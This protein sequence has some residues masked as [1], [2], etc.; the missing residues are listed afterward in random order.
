MFLGAWLPGRVEA[1][2]GGNVLWG[3][4][5]PDAALASGARQRNPLSQSCQTHGFPA[6]YSRS[7]EAEPGD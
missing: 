4:D 1:E 5:P 7:G 6:S 2:G 3:H